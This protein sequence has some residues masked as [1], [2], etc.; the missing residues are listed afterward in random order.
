MESE[1]VEEEMPKDHFMLK[2]EVTYNEEPPII[3]RRPR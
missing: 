1:E 3:M 2:I